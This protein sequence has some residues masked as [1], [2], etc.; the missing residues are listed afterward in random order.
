MRKSL[1]ITVAALMLV[2]GF[3]EGV[4]M[5]ARRTPPANPSSLSVTALYEGRL[6][7]KVV[8]VRTDQIIEPGA[9]RVGARIHT[10]GLI[11]AIK[12]AT[13]LAQ[14]QGPMAAGIPVPAEFVSNDGRRRRVVQFHNAS[15]RSAA[16]PLTQLLRIALTPPNA[17]PCIGSVRVED[18]RQTYD[19]I[20]SPGGGGDLTG[21]QK[22]LGLTAPVRCRLG[23]RPIAGFRPGAS[24]RN[25]FMTG[26]VF[27]T[28]ARPSRADVWVLSDLAIGTVLGQAHIALSGLTVSGARPAVIAA[29][30]PAARA[31]PRR[32]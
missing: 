32:K 11:G 6:V 8:D 26:E 23:F 13:F 31:R 20:A 9:F 22:A 27:A 4:A 30:R 2:S 18:G 24:L 19:L 17:S 29:P 7:V 5:E 1:L 12:A 3:G 25:P 15:G 28:Y 14:A 16:D 10:T 21:A